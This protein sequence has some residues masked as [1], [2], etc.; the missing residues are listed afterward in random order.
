MGGPPKTRRLSGRLLLA[1]AACALLLYAKYLESAVGAIESRAAAPR[2]QRYEP[3]AAA[4]PG[5]EGEGAY[6]HEEE[7]EDEEEELGPMP[8][9]E[10]EAGEEEPPA[11]VIC[12]LKGGR[13]RGSEGFR[14]AQRGPGGAL[15]AG[16]AR[17]G[18]PPP[19]PGRALPVRPRLV[20]RRGARE[21]PRGAVHRGRVELPSGEGPVAR[22]AAAAVPSACT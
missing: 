19:P 1:L 13:V 15:R 9:D 8:P 4:D 17:R 5:G 12:S 16:G 14:A 22:E 21:A 10:E 7:A 11:P 3:G 2:A 18:L 20:P 6:Y